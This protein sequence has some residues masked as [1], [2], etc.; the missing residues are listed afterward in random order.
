MAKV[1]FSANIEDIRGK[2][3]NSVFTAGRSGAVLRT[4]A[5]VKNPNTAAQS[6]VRANL[7][8]ASATFKGL[9]SAQ[10]TQWA[11]YAA[12]IVRH[13][14]VNGT[15][16]NPA[17][18]AIFVALASKF[19]Q[20]TPGGTIPV[21]PPASAFAGDS[22]A[23]TAAGASGSVT[24][25]ASAGSGTNIKTELLLQR[26]PSA[27]RTPGAKGYRSKRF[28]AFAGTGLTSNVPVVPG[29][30]VPAYRFVNTATGQDTGL[31]MLPPVTVS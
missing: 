4:R 7:S 24:F 22:I 13:N 14:P 28:V 9:T 26:L 18:N 8:K 1:S 12:T 27:N 19:L 20:I 11:N 30:Y 10:V 17:P 3:G 29:I 6:G 5:Q 21:T 31:I 15:A 16:Y 25:T 23:V 2:V